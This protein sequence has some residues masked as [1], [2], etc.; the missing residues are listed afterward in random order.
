[1][2]CNPIVTPSPTRI[3][4]DI[5]DIQLLM[6]TSLPA[7]ITNMSSHRLH[8][9]REPSEVAAVGG[10]SAPI[11]DPAGAIIALPGRLGYGKYNIAQSPS[12]VLSAPP[13]P[14]NLLRTR[15]QPCRVVG[16]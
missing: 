3:A 1:M 8:G 11:S 13:P 9:R 2:V 12:Q 5:S 6:P 16:S 14:I 10:R 7:S 15:Y 4:D